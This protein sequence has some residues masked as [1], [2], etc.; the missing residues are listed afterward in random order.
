M[1]W[2]LVE[3]NIT[4]TLNVKCFLTLWLMLHRGSCFVLSLYVSILGRFQMCRK[5]IVQFPEFC[6]GSQIVSP[7]HLIVHIM[8]QV[9][10]KVVLGFESESHCTLL[11]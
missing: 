9:W 3:D 6:P 7:S 5:E 8:K 1:P 4:D 11:H 2:Y 10:Y